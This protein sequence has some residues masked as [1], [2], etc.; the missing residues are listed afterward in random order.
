MGTT[1]W[2]LGIG[3]G[4]L[5]LN[6]AH[7]GPDRSGVAAEVNDHVPESGAGSAQDHRAAGRQPA[8]IA[9]RVA[10]LEPG[11]IDVVHQADVGLRI[12]RHPHALP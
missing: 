9:V 4:W 8:V 3:L 1:C 12:E 2:F 11:E 7:G 5:E 10:T 6:F